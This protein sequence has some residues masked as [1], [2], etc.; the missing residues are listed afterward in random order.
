MVVRSYSECVDAMLQYACKYNA[1]RIS[2]YVSVCESRKSRTQPPNSLVLQPMRTPA[3]LLAG[4]PSQSM[5]RAPSA[6]T[7]TF[8]WT[9]LYEY[10]L[11]RRCWC[12]TCGM[13]H[14]PLCTPQ[15]RRRRDDDA[16][17]FRWC[18]RFSWCDW[19]T[20]QRNML[21]PNDGC[22]LW[23]QMV[24][25]PSH[26]MLLLVFRDK[27]WTGDSIDTA[28]EEIKIRMSGSTLEYEIRC[29][30]THNFHLDLS[31]FIANEHT[32]SMVN[33]LIPRTVVR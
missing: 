28:M 12:P 7:Q 30:Q 16:H 33:R 11:V 15:H 3:N 1:S 19:W 17:R 27:I 22:V 9:L 4:N 10:S 6:S 23:N 26:P 20:P 2:G 5:F 13:R 31:R 29:N 8:A 32:H 18:A 14:S 25:R 24:A 21:C